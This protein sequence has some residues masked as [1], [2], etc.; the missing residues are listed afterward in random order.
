MEA[1]KHVKGKRATMR[2]HLKG[3]RLVARV[4]ND[5]R[6][7]VVGA[8]KGRKLKRRGGVGKANVLRPEQRASHQRR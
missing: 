3:I 7:L 4:H 8:L 5:K 2:P 6:S 1:V